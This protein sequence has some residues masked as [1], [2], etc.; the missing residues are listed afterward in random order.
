MRLYVWTEF[1]G[2]AETGGWAEWFLRTGLPLLPVLA[3]FGIA[4]GL[5]MGLPSNVPIGASEA[6]PLTKS[7]SGEV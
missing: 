5:R 6:S 2:P 7:R 3:D 1:Q 4:Q